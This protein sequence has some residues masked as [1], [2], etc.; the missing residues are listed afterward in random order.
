[1]PKKKDLFIIQISWLVYR[2]KMIRG[3]EKEREREREYI[4]IESM[5]G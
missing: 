4:T 5:R 1:V 3:T 2:D